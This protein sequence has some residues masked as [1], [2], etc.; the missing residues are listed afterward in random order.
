MRPR[1]VLLQSLAQGAGVLPAGRRCASARPTAS[2]R[3]LFLLFYL[4]SSSYFLHPVY[5]LL[6]AT[7]AGD[8]LGDNRE[9]LLLSNCGKISKGATRSNRLNGSSVS[10]IAGIPV[11]PTLERSISPLPGTHLAYNSSCSDSVMNF[12]LRRE[13]MPL[14]KSLTDTNDN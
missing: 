14:L 6:L 12:A 7:E 9:M 5:S 1:I 11:V 3:L 10:T 8:Y 13:R 4:T 2:R